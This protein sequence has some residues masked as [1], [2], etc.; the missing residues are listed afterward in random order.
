MRK[1]G[2]L[3]GTAPRRARRAVELFSDGRFQP[4]VVKSK[5]VYARR[6]RNNRNLDQ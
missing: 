1:E 2:K 4:R 6:P 5:R 3:T